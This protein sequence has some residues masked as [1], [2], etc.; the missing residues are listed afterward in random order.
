MTK[1]FRFRIM[2]VLFALCMVAV[3]MAVTYTTSYTI[4]GLNKQRLALEAN[5]EAERS[6]IRVLQAEWSYLA[7]P[8]RIERMATTYLKMGRPVKTQV[9]LARDF[10]KATAP[11]MVASAKPVAP[12]VEKRIE[13]ASAEPA[14]LPAAV[15][16]V[17]Y[18][19]NT[20]S[21]VRMLLASFKQ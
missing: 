14:K 2:F 19:A 10:D 8:A 21:G 7:E 1:Q 4:D 17:A 5:V 11:A 15:H 16:P 20:P 12:K 3:P 13:V 18:Q 9:A 6:A